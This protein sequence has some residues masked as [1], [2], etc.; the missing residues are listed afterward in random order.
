[1]PGIIS[2]STNLILVVED[3]GLLRVSL[4]DALRQSG[5]AVDEAGNGR[6]A[7]ACMRRRVPDLVL[8]DLRMPIMDGFSFR[9]EQRQDPLLAKIPV[10]LVSANGEEEDAR[11]LGAVGILDKPVQLP[12][13]IAMINTLPRANGHA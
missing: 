3:E 13:L 12:E 8:L 2:R 11:S 9:A 4:A 7:L 1:M 10:I 6:A 5:Y